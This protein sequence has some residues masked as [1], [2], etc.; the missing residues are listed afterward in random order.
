MDEATLKKL[1]F[2]PVLLALIV[3]VVVWQIFRAPDRTTLT[4][5]TGAEGGLYHRLAKQMKTAIEASHSDLRI[6][7][8]P[9]AG[10]NENIRRIDQ[11]KA[12]LALVQNDAL[13]GQSVRSLAALYPEVLHLITRTNA[14]IRTL[15]DLPGKRTGIGAPGSGTAQ[16]STNLLAFA[17]VPRDANRTFFASLPVTLAK[18]QNGQL[19]A[20]FFLTGLGSP[21][22]RTALANPS[23][24]LAGIQMPEEN[25]DAKATAEQFTD[26]FRVHYPYVA[27]HV[28]PQLAYRGR[29]VSPVPSLSVQAVLVC[30]QDVD[31]EIIE[32]IARTLFTQRAVLSQKE[33]AFT[34]LDESAAG[35]GLQ[36]PLHEGADNFYRRKEPGFFAENVEIMGFI[37]TV[38]L[39]VWSVA[40]WMRN[41]YLL[42]KKNRIDTYYEAVEDVIRRLHDGTDLNEIDELET[43]LLKIRQRASAEL[44]Q[45]KLAADESFII[46]QN[47]LNGGQAMLV[48][49]REKIRSSPD[50]DA[51][52]SNSAP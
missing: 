46:Y 22:L 32:R 38:G 3:A 36:F 28:I 33:P 44:V 39:L 23:L 12:Q 24:A 43:E 26:G 8:Q 52:K 34:Y 31:A 4:L 25:T 40:S 51:E 14:H 35:V 21:A 5:T 1:R 50:D 18:L 41:W 7:L 30:H 10:S 29:P 47:M 6:Q 19:D 45:E 13:G 20:A 27:P 49:M 37:L 42:R 9:S 11:G 16:I 48:R 17:N 15:A 2:A